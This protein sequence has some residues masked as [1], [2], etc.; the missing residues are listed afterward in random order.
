M[1]HGLVLFAHGSRDARWAQPFE[2]IQQRV[3]TLLPGIEVCLAYLE[4]MEPDLGQAIADLAGKGARRIRV[5]PLFLGY[6]GH[7]RE[8]LPRLVTAI[9]A[10]HPGLNI[11][12]SAPAGE[13]ERV[14]DALVDYCIR[15]LVASTG[16]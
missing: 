3:R 7:L 8:D 13:D 16:E 1:T 11:E 15:D 2:T 5:L 9:A 14:L 4:R 12:L 10:D 6:G